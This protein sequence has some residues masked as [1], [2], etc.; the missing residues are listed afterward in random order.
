[1]TIAVPSE[2]SACRFDDISCQRTVSTTTGGVRTVVAMND[3]H[4]N[5]CASAEWGA[6]LAETI[7]PQVLAGVELGDDVLEIGSGPG[8][9]TNLL[10]GRVARLTATC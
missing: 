7:F 4:L 10:Q 6:F 1:M 5:V 3:D 2:D 8:L 9:S